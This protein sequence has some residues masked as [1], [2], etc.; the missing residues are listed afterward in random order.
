MTEFKNLSPLRK[1]II[2]I[3]ALNIE[4]HRFAYQTFT[5]GNTWCHWLSRWITMWR[6]MT[7]QS[8]V[9]F[10][11]LNPMSSPKQLVAQLEQTATLPHGR[12]ERFTGYGVISLPFTSG[13][14]LAL[15]KFPAT[16]IG[17]GYTSVWHRTPEG[18]WTIYQN[19]QPELACSRYYGRALAASHVQEID[20]LWEGPNRFAVTVGE[21]TVLRWSVQLATT[22][23]TRLMNGVTN[24]LPAQWRYKPGVLKQ[25]GKLST[26]LLDAGKI[27]FMGKVPNGQSFKASPR[28]TWFVRHSQ[29]TIGGQ[30]LGKPG[31]LEHQSRLADF[32]LPQYG[33]FCLID[34]FFEPYDPEKHTLKTGRVSI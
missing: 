29:A 14:V 30:D 12:S 28:L 20:I 13:H 34:A 21:G 4:V 22:G 33:L 2:A 3:I 23:L 31:P 25:M 19:V 18:R 32:W 10:C 9:K 24:H 27:S 17:N 26:Q 7:F 1:A 16:S 8:W 11:T 15:R 6:R 5:L